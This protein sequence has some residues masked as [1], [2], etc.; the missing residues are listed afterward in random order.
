MKDKACIPYI[1]LRYREN[2]LQP[3]ELNQDSIFDQAKLTEVRLQTL[4]LAGVT[5]I[6]S[7]EGC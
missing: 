7:A 5:A 6:D 2:F 3:L 4:T 1:E